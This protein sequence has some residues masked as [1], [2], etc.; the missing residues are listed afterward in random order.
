[1]ARYREKSPEDLRWNRIRRRL[2]RELDIQLADWREEAL[3]VLLAGAFHQYVEAL[4]SGKKLE[5]EGEYKSW[6]AEALDAELRELLAGPSAP[7][8]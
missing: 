8:G 1:M 5:L 7:V 6:V 3:N 2:T 4:D